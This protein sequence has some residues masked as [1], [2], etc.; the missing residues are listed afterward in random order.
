MCHDISPED[1]SCGIMVFFHSGKK[2]DAWT[3]LFTQGTEEDELQ[4]KKKYLIDL[5]CKMFRVPA[6]QQT[7]Y[8]DQCVYYESSYRTDQ[9]IRSG[10]QSNTRAGTFGAVLKMGDSL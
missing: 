2:L 6:D 10:F 3:S 5:M 9:F 4:L 8:F 1:E 7:V